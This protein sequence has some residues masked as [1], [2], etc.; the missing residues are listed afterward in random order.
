MKVIQRIPL[1]QYSYIEFEDEYE[2]VGAAMAEHTR[3]INEYSNAG[4]PDKEWA[5]LRN[6]MFTTGQFDPNIEGLNKAQRY[7]INQCK[8]ALRSVE[9]ETEPVIN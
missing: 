3:I 6:K 1:E 5:Q 9:K 4:I 2:S 7:F 8:L